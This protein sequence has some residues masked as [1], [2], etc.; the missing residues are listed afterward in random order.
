LSCSAHQSYFDLC[1]LVSVQSGGKQHRIFPQQKS[2]YSRT[3][4]F[5]KWQ[6]D[7]TR[8]LVVREENQTIG[9]QRQC[10]FSDILNDDPLGLVGA[11]KSVDVIPVVQTRR[12]HQPRRFVSL[13]EFLR[14]PLIG[15]EVR[16]SVLADLSRGQTAPWRFSSDFAPHPRPANTRGRSE[17]SPMNRRTGEGSCLISV[18]VATIWSGL[19]RSGC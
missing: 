3:D 2:L 7:K 9:R 8:E 19:M 13:E 10:A 15:S 6:A 5:L 17:R 1:S 16:D 11:F 18:G 4:Y 14:L 12:E